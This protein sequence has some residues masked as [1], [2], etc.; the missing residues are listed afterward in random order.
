MIFLLKVSLGDLIN[1]F[2]VA[3][4]IFIQYII[5][6]KKKTNVITVKLHYHVL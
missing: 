1:I 3:Y 6:K 2:M 5:A 4:R